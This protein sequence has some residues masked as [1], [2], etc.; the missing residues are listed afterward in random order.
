MLAAP[1]IA[2]PIKTIKSP[3]TNAAPAVKIKYLFNF[4]SAKISD[5]KNQ[6]AKAKTIARNGKKKKNVFFGLH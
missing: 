1:E 6:I 4:S 2:I 3:K 5:S